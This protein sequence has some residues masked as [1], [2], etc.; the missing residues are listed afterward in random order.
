MSISPPISTVRPRRIRWWQAPFSGETWHRTLYALV[1]L[2]VAIVALPLAV[3]GRSEAV[4]RFQSRM[5]WRLLSLQVGERSFRAVD[6]R[7]IAHAALS[8]PLDVVATALVTYLWTQG[9]LGNLA[10]PLELALLG[11][12]LNPVPEGTWGGPSLA[13][14]W[15]VHAAAGMVILFI[16]PWIIKGITEA[17]GSLLRRLLGAAPAMLA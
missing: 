11:E 2:P 1:A 9:T 3:F 14:A 15:A 17:Q 8:L 6:G 4:A 5:A 13:G 10:Y 7:V 16:A 12:E